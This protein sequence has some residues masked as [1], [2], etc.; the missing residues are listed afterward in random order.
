MGSNDNEAGFYVF[1]YAGVD[2][3]TLNQTRQDE[4]GYGQFF[5]P[6]AVDAAA[7][8]VALAATTN[9]SVYRY[10]YFGDW[11]NL[12]LY[13]AS[14]A[15]HTSETSMVFGTMADLSGA[16][17]TPLQVEVSDYL[18]HAWTTFARDPVGGLKGLGWPSYNQSES[19]LVRL[20]YGNESVA[21][22]ANPASYDAICKKLE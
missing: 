7:K 6:T 13:P 4:I 14:R 1:R 18:Q 10:D 19:T 22:Y 17:S 11:P 20:G 3:I 16:P 12:R 15:Y 8:S 9:A 21:S 5:C 2:Q